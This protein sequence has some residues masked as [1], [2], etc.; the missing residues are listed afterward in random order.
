MYNLALLLEATANNKDNFE[1]ALSHYLQLNEKAPDDRYIQGI[2]RV[3]KA[4]RN[5]NRIKNI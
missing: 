1:E 3:E 4:I 5:L 2:G